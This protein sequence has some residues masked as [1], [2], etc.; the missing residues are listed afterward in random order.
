MPKVLLCC[1]WKLAELETLPIMNREGGLDTET[2]QHTKTKKYFS[3]DW[4]LLNK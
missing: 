3:T 2:Y 4:Y 1:M